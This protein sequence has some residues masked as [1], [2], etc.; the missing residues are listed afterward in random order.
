MDTFFPIQTVKLHSNDI[1]WMLVSIKKFIIARQQAFSCGNIDLW[2]HYKRKVK[3]AI[4]FK[5]KNFYS[6]EVRHLKKSDC[7]S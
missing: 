7:R 5:K 6:D 3:Y 2:R 1:P 4:Q